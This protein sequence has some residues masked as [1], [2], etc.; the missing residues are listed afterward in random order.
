ML[1][2][3][4]VT[5]IRNQLNSDVYLLDTCIQTSLHVGENKGKST[6]LGRAIL[7]FQYFPMYCLAKAKWSSQFWEG[8]LLA[9]RPCEGFIS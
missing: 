8:C 1:G 4:Y 9:D 3:L 6:C 5:Q 7:S 2:S